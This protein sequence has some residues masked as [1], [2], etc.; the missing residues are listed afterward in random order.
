MVLV[1]EG[2]G[3]PGVNKPCE[4]RVGQLK[5]EFLESLLQQLVVF[6]ELQ[7]FWLEQ[8][9]GQERVGR[10]EVGELPE[11]QL[12]GDALGVGV[13]EVAQLA[14]LAGILNHL[15]LPAFDS[16]SP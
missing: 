1:H 11:G 7:D 12:T 2:S 13:A 8:S 15:R 10:V 4:H 6:G 5:I 14:S 16:D 3:V 9:V